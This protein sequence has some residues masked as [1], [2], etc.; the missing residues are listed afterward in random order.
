VYT[1]GAV[2]EVRVV[3][4]ELKF[5]DAHGCWTEVRG[6]DGKGTVACVVWGTPRPSPPLPIP[7]PTQHAG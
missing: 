6:S 5:D 7:I 1:P 4:V 3:A 2:P